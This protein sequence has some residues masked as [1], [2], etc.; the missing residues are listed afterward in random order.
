VRGHGTQAQK[1]E[2]EPTTPASGRGHGFIGLGLQTTDFGRPA[3]QT[4]AGNL[5]PSTKKTRNFQEK[6]S[7]PSQFIIGWD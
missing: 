7:T 4:T 1:G 5:S 6:F 3:K 2:R